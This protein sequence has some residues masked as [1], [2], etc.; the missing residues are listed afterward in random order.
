MQSPLETPTSASDPKSVKVNLTTGTGVDIEWKDG[1]ASHYEF[2][3][4]RNA[5]PC[6][7]C[8][9]ERAK[10]GL[11]PGQSPKPVPGALPMFKPTAKPLSA[12]P[13]GK[14]AIKFNWND[15]HDLG[16]Y[17]WKLLR[18]LCPCEECNAPRTSPEA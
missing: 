18:E 15:N 9:D 6:A 5:C 11:K 3:Y 16:L 8:E 12:E 2:V 1:H 14:Y 17:S 4:L 7:M 10:T 13:V